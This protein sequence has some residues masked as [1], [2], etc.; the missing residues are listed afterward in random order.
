MSLNNSDRSYGGVAKT[1]HW[2][3][4]LLIFAV[5]PV[6]IVAN[7]MSFET[8]EQL[9]RKVLL[10]SVHKT[11]GVTIFF[12]ALARIV[13]AMRQPKPGLLNANRPL[14]AT[15]A[16][17]VHWLL[18]GSL[19][20]VP[21]TGWL[22]HA[23]TTGYAPIW[24]PFGQSLPFV[25]KDDAVAD[26]F[27]GLHQVLIVVLVG[28]ILFHVAGA[29]K[30]HVV[31]KDNTLRRMLPYSPA[32]QSPPALHRSVVPVVAAVVI[33]GAALGIGATLGAFEDNRA[34]WS[35]AE[36]EDVQSQWVVQDGAINISVSQF[37]STVTGRFADWNATITFDDAEPG[38]PAGT[39]DVTISTGSLTLGSVTAQALGPDYFDTVSFPTARYVADILA[40]PDGYLA[41]G[42]LTIKDHPVSITLN[43]DLSVTDGIADMSGTVLLDRRDFGIG[44]N[45]PDETSL[46]FAVRVNVA[47]TASKTTE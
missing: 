8:S 21:L 46:G 36:L 18:Y 34:A 13:W 16:E 17:T 22:H 24:W 10:F 30:H 33:W 25:P 11:L 23:A 9:A 1:F 4:A 47:L 35:A 44:D 2:L 19:V 5:V 14:E 28:S 42:T 37:G 6:G 26:L 32:M 31:D 39:V 27:A 40:I 20:L 12:V 45:M 3:T 38:K 43:F 29:L 15:L 7:D 41:E